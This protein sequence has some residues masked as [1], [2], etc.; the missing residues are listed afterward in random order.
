MSAKD[1]HGGPAMT[2]RDAREYLEASDRAQ[3]K[4]EAV[5]AA[6]AEWKVFLM[7]VAMVRAEMKK[8]REDETRLKYSLLVPRHE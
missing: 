2:E 7:E 8:W 1:N 3:V 5:L 6:V 4:V